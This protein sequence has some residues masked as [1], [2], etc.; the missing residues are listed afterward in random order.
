MLGIFVLLCLILHQNVLAQENTKPR[1]NVLIIPTQHW[2][3]V[4]LQPFEVNRMRHVNML[5]HLMEIMENKPGFEHFTLDGEVHLVDD[6]VEIMPSKKDEL[7]KLISEGRVIIGPWYNQPNVFMVSGESIIRNLYLGIN[8]GKQYGKVMNICFLPD[9]FG[10]N[11]QLPQIMKGFGM[12]DVF[13]MRGIP[14]PYHGMFKWTGSDKTQVFAYNSKYQEGNYY[15][16]RE[17]EKT[18]AGKQAFLEDFDTYLE[19]RP[20]K[21]IPITVIINGFDM[22]WAIADIPEKV[23]LLNQKRDH[24]DVRISDFPEAFQVLKDFYKDHDDDYMTFS[25]EI[26]DHTGISIIPAS[27]STRMDL[28]IANRS[29]ENLLEKN[30]E[31]LSSIFWLSG[32]EYPHNQINKAWH[33]LVKN[34]HHDNIAGASHDND[35]YAVMA[36]LQRVKE[37]GSELV[38]KSTEI[39]TDRLIQQVKL[40][41]EEYGFVVFNTLGWKR[42]GIEDIVLDIPVNLH[43][44]NPVISDGDNE[45][46]IYPDDFETMLRFGMEDYT[47]IYHYGPEVK[48]YFASVPLNDVPAFGYKFFKIK[49]KGVRIPVWQLNKQS[50]LRSGAHQAENTFLKININP[51]GTLNIYDKRTGKEYSNVHYFL[52]EG[53]A[54]SGFE[55]IQPLRNEKIKTLGRHADIRLIHENPFKITY[56]I[57]W[58]LQL[59]KELDDE[60]LRRDTEKLVKCRIQSLITLR[61][62]SPRIDIETTIDN[63]A[64]DHRLRVCFP[65]NLYASKSWAHQPFDVVSRPTPMPREQWEDEGNYWFPVD[66]SHPMYAFVDISDGENGLMIANKGLTLYEIERDDEAKVIEID[67]IRSLDRIHTKNIGKTKDIRIPDAQMIGTYSFE[68]SIIPHEGIWTNAIQDAYQYLVPVH[69]TTPLPEGTKDVE[70]SFL[71]LDKRG[72]S[73]MPMEHSYIELSNDDILVSALKK[74]EHRNALVIRLYNP[75][76]E[77]Q[78][79][80]CKIAPL[81]KRVINIQ[82]VNLLEEPIEGKRYNKNNVTIELKPKKIISLMIEMEN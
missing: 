6:Y 21:N 60:Y 43:I 66:E 40:G 41:P 48:R 15:I 46:T 28:K 45:Y 22:Q 68:Y 20:N 10:L 70:L 52:D 80:N 50:T 3:R 35:Y 82:E 39:L 53:E 27:Q 2:D 64:K 7:I 61:A 47:G 26:R 30:T 63:N 34:H 36:E 17:M 32:F 67:L 4:W 24:L 37:I 73:D 8:R 79:V 72:L 12:E 55:H 69:T 81:E 71:G 49:D 19:Q 77:T 75:G 38:R 57:E 33:Y 25:G 23:E 5:D 59:P 14:K 65:S 9:C 44:H 1:N 11:S 78:K 56:K 42:S 51:D 31:P 74:H 16:K 62:G 58:E 18:E 29:A 54:G 13:F 76:D